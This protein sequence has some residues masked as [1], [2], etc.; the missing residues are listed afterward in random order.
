[1]DKQIQQLPVPSR[2]RAVALLKLASVDSRYIVAPDQRVA[3]RVGDAGKIERSTDRG[4]TWKTQ[5]SAASADLTG[6]SAPS[7]KICWVVGKSG[8]ILL[9]TDGGKHWKQITS[10]IA[11]DL[12]EIHGTDELHAW[13]SDISSQNKFETS[14]GGATWT[15]IPAE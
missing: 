12:G 1:M 14:N 15:C 8:T 4:Q 10:P 3:W 5:S 6:G 2:S 13:I 11:T 9:T 7:D